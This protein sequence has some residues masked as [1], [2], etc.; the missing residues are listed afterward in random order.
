MAENVKRPRQLQLSTK[1]ELEKNWH[2]LVETVARWYDQKPA[3]LEFVSKARLGK[4]GLR[5]WGSKTSLMGKRTKT[6]G[7]RLTHHVRGVASVQRPLDE[8]MERLERW[9]KDER[10][11]RHEV[12]VKTLTT[13]LMYE[14]EYERD[15]QLVLQQHE[16]K[17]FKPFVLEKCREKLAFMQIMKPSRKPMPRYPAGTGRSRWR[18]VWRRSMPPCSPI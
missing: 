15:R 12:R 4:H 16:S 6:L 13:R 9:L 11:H 17:D 5:P 2:W 7:R 14:L 10:Q 8:V 18:P 1:R 3:F